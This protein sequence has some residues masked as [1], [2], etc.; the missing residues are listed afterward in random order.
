MRTSTLVAPAAIV[1]PPTGTAAQTLPLKYSSA[2]P[3]SVPTVAVAD[4]STGSNVIAVLG[5][6]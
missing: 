3:V 2:L 5:L 6:A 1:T 4:A